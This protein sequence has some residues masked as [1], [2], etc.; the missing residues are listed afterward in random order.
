MRDAILL[1]SLW[2][3]CAVE[4]KGLVKGAFLQ[5]LCPI[6]LFSNKLQH[7]PFQ[8][9]LGFNTDNPERNRFKPSELLLIPS[10][11]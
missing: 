9:K 5:K 11:P 4:S 1:P 3:S 10:S 8:Q 6:D 2:V 7:H